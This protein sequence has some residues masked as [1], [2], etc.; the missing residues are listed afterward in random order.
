MEVYLKKIIA[1]ETSDKLLPFWED[2]LFLYHIGKAIQ[3]AGERKYILAEKEFEKAY[4]FGGP[5]RGSAA[6]FYGMYAKE[7]YDY[8]NSIGREMD[9]K[10]E[11]AKCLEYYKNNGY[12][13]HAREIEKII[14]KCNSDCDTE[15]Q[16]FEIDF[17]IMKKDLEPFVYKKVSE[18]SFEK[19]SKC[20]QYLQVWQKLMKQT[21]L[22]SEHMIYK[23]MLSILSEFKIDKI[24]FVTNDKERY[25][26]RYNNL[27]YAFDQKSIDYIGNYFYEHKKVF[28]ASKMNKNF[29]E[30][31]KIANTFADDH[32]CS[33]AGIPIFEKDKVKAF[34]YL[35]IRMSDNWV[36]VTRSVII[37]KYQAD[38]IEY[39]LSDLL[40]MIEKFELKEE[41]DR[42]NVTV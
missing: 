24:L 1:I 40:N 26:I 20:I 6:L 3:Y 18:Y 31:E 29:F 36:N 5:S 39:I 17:A 15:N 23:V 41:N 38:F 33:I 16:N 28:V 13:I 32:L 21:Y 12:S 2:D 37:E 34:T 42:L 25:R 4:I 27:G 9:A 22:S 14:G 7:V 35:Y 30:F 11:I 10:E 19:N 8:L